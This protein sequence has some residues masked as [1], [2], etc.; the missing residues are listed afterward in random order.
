MDSQ[1]VEARALEAEITALRRACVE[2]PAPGEDTS[3]VRYVAFL[4]PSGKGEDL[5][6]RRPGPPHRLFPSTRR[7]REL[8]ICLFQQ[9]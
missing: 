4:R 8:V 5:Y 9:G 6:S 7:G 1:L 2:P 3:R